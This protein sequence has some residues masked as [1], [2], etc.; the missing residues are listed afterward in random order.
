MTD[1]SSVTIIVYLLYFRNYK[2]IRKSGQD[3]NST[4]TAKSGQKAGIS[5]NKF[6]PQNCASYAF[7]ALYAVRL[8]EQRKYN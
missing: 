7:Y 8:L 5:V 4:K 6:F 3:K 2:Q 1:N